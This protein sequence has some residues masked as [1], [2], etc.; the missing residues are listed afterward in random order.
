MS[1]KA[2]DDAARKFRR[3]GGFPRNWRRFSEFERDMLSFSAGFLAGYNASNV[4]WQKKR[5]RK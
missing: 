5:G 4:M 3:E 1:R 2:W